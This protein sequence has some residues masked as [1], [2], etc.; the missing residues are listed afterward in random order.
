MSTTKTTKT[1]QTD[2]YQ[3]NQAG[4]D[5]YNKMTPQMAQVIQMYM[6]NPLTAS[7]FQ[8]QLGM[9]NKQIGQQGQSD[10]FTL[11]HNAR[12]AGQGGN[13][14]YL[15]GQLAK[16]GRAG[17][18]NRANAF[19]QLLLGAEGN[20]RWAAG[21]AGGY[22]PLQT[23]ATMNSTQTQKTSGLGTWLPQV[24]GIGLGLATGGLGFAGGAIAST[25][26][27]GSPFEG[28]LAL[29]SSTPFKGQGL[30]NPFLKS[31]W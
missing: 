20:R 30:V 9:A 21:G 17:S 29:Q 1:D 4:M 24:A 26:R 13:N 5:A 25:P 18:A 8:N 14:P 27:P 6:S 3:F 23:G 15:Q 19:T 28:A 11:L 31:G 2:K 7:Y 16:Q 22:Q 10:I 12:S